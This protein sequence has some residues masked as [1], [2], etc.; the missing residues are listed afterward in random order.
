MSDLHIDDFYRD[1]AK[2]LVL[3]Y[4][5]FPR[6]IT[7]YVEDISGTDTPDEFGLHSKRH[8]A[9]L[10]ALLWLG[11]TDYLS[12]KTLVRQEAL[13]EAVLT[14]RTFLL[15]NSGFHSGNFNHQAPHA[16]PDLLIN[17]LREQLSTGTSSTLAVC[18]RHIMAISRQLP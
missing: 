13:E 1:T 10:N 6:K 2:A 15:L 5:A 3:L 16:S 9:G 17:Q 8:D 14:H 11:S 4:N 7:L 12:Y 18:V